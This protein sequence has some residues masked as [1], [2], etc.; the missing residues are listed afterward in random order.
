MLLPL[1]LNLETSGPTA[2][3]VE[4]GGAYYGK[5][6]FSIQLDATVINGSDGSPTYAW[7]IVSGGTGSFADNTVLD[8]VFTPDSAAE[9]VLR[10]TVSTSDTSDVTDDATVFASAGGGTRSQFKLRMIQKDDEEV[11]ALLV[12]LKNRR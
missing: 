11:L 4:A 5:P 12:A 2:P 10:L 6:G 1:I 3:T 9:Y 7:T 8:A